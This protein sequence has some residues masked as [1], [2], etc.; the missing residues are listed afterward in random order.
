MPDSEQAEAIHEQG[1][2][3]SVNILVG[4]TGTVSFA[5]LETRVEELRHTLAVA[6]ESYV[7][8]AYPEESGTEVSGQSSS[9]AGISF[10]SYSTP[11]ADPASLPWNVAS[12]AQR[13]I[14]SLAVELQAD[15]CVLLRSDLAMLQTEAMQSL[16]MPILEKQCDLVLPV[17]PSSRFEGLIN[18]AVLAPLERTLYGLRIKYP[19]AQDF[20]C[21]R[22]M[23]EVLSDQSGVHQAKSTALTWP[24]RVAA[25]NGISVCQA[26]VE[27][28]HTTQ[29]EGLELTTVLS[30]LLDS[31]YAEMEKYAPFW[32]RVRSSRP[33][34]TSGNPTQESSDGEPVDVK[35]LVESFML[36]TRNLQEVWGLVLPPVALLELKK[37]ARL[38]PEE[39]RMPDEIWVRTIYDFALAH[40]LRTI[41][42]SH[43]LGALTPLYLGW[44]A[45]YVQEVSEASSAVVEQRLERLAKAYEENKPY[46]LSRWRW[47]DRFNP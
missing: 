35:P 22:Q 28:R 1:Q 13:A 42:R 33:T 9:Q 43:L 10:Q 45:S 6:P 19:L 27:V 8:I 18:H 46:L 30:S 25:L 20:S 12:A 31:A 40:R 37:L 16:M 32:Q 41:N 7:V 44:V 21:S 15:A 23:C 34:E 36:G 11:T 14:C 17:Y 38:S 47:P 5:D 4:V 3:R 24:A 26:N 39:F 2:T 29:R